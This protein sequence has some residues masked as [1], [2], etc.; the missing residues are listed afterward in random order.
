LV[1]RI[2][3]P[4]GDEAAKVRFEVLPYVVQGGLDIGCGEKK[5]WPHMIGVDSQ[6]DDQLFGMHTRPDIVCDATRLVIFADQF[7]ECVFS[8][9]LLEHVVDYRA[10]LAEWWRVVAPGGV[11]IL[12]LP[13]KDLYPN[14]GQPG[15]NPDHK[16]DFLPA[17]IVDAMFALAPDCT[18][19]KNETRDQAAEYSFLQIYR[20]EPA[21]TGWHDVSVT[22]KPEKSAGLVRVGGHG[23][24]LWASSVLWHLKNQG[25]HTTVYAAKGG[26]EVLRHDPH[27][28]RLIELPD[29]VMTDADMLEYWH[30]ESLKHD[31]FI[32][33]I[34][35]VENRLLVHPASIEFHHSHALRHRL[36]N[37]NYLEQVHDYADLPYEFHQKFYPT[38]EELAFCRAMRAKLPGPLVVLNPGGS[39][40][41][42]WW[43][44]SQELMRLLAAEKVSCLLL[45]ELRDDTLEPIEPYAHVVGLEWPVRIALTMALL[46]DAVVATESLIANAVAFEPMLKVITLSHSSNENLT[47]HWLNTAAI[48]PTG[49][50]CHPCHRIHGQHF[51]FCRQDKTTRASACQTAAGAGMIASF[52]LENLRRGGLLPALEKAA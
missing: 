22:P 33:L 25:Y 49:L 51:G 38:G 12:Y 16:H 17:D 45:G 44:H 36:M 27:I 43:P 41:T 20:K 31:T 18:L 11:L 50:A 2:D 6:I 4:Q 35:S 21:G 40:P 46:A 39:G 7:A 1:W 13:H 37:R 5:V 9:H 34:G 19:L 29:R 47:K 10:T 30:V 8:S 23:D 42:K 52:V 26:A 3:G 15:S 24:A 14:I 32:N 48:E 28:D